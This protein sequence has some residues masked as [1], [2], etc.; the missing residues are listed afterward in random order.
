M[1][2]AGDNAQVAAS[3]IDAEKSGAIWPNEVASQFA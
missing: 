1:R 3:V 2:E